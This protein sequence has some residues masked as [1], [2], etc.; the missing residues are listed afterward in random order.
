MMLEVNYCKKCAC[1]RKRCGG[2]VINSLF[3][4]SRVGEVVSKWARNGRG[5]FKTHVE[6]G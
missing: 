5:T 3:V 1:M 4:R 6:Y 2:I